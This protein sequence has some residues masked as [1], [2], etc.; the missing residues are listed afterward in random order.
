MR[1]GSMLWHCQKDRLALYLMFSIS[2]RSVPSPLGQIAEN[3]TIGYFH[4]EIASGAQCFAFGKRAHGALPFGVNF[5]SLGSRPAR[6]DLREVFN[7]TFPGGRVRLGSMFWH[8]Q[9]ER[10]ALYLMLSI[11]A[12]SVP[13]PLGQIAENFT[14]GYFR[15][16]IASGAQCFAFDKRAH[17]ALRFGVNLSSLGS[18][19]ALPDLGEIFNFTFPGGRVCLGSMFLHCQKDR[20]ALYL[21]LSISARSVP[22]PLGQIA[23]NFTIGYFHGEIASGAQCFAFGKRAHGALPFGV[24]FSSLGSRPARP[25][26]RE[27]FNF[28][29]P[30]GR[31]CLGSMFWHCQKDRLALYLMFS[32]SARSVPSPLGQIAENFT[33]GYFHGEIASGAQ[34]FAFDKR[35]HGA[36]PFG[37]NFSSLG[38]RPA[39]PDLREIFNFTFPGGRVRLG[40]M[41]WHC[42]KDRLALYL[43]LSISARSVPSPLGQ[44][45]EN[46]TIGYFHGEIASGSHCFAFDKRAHGA[47]PFGVNFSSLSSRPARPDLREIFNFTFPVGRVRLGS[48][49]WHCQK[50]RLALYLMLSISAR[51]VPSPLG[52][53][54]ENFTIG[55]FH[56]EIASGSHCFAF[57]KRAHGALPF[58]VNFSSLSS[59][60]ARPDLREIFN[61]TFPGGRVCLGS[62]FW[63]CQKD[64][65]ALYLML[66]ISARSV[67]SPLGQIAENFTIGYFRGGYC[68]WGPMFCI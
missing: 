48:M 35:A 40:S 45:A 6:P 66:S 7:F 15:G 4:G 24:N 18:R 53:K 25:D 57:D 65:L 47:L 23:E 2:A 19:P 10:L 61:F 14:I 8:C 29:F 67:P 62:M 32:I 60:P 12:R 27:I 58:G 52:Q 34:C 56:G 11:S 13:S 5:S 16:E 26:L 17:G 68:V 1:L 59:R 50:D 30:G 44:K 42:Q 38:S 41:F 63:H 31:V 36:L 20:L 37:F 39:R 46:F 21:M 49:F 51:S 54:A 43:M 33:I 64:R 9:K 28:T 3:F 22:S 55:Y